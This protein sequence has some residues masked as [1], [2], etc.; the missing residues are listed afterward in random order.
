[1][2]LDS[3]LVCKRRFSDPA[4]QRFVNQNVNV[5]SSAIMMT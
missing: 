1:M 5:S 3:L 2:F 4:A